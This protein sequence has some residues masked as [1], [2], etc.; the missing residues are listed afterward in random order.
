MTL[1]L[2]VGF[3]LFYLMMMLS[4]VH[5]RSSGQSFTFFHWNL[6]SI[7]VQ[8]YTKVSILTAYTLVHNS[9][10]ICHS[11]TYLNSEASTD[12]QNLKNLV[13]ICYALT[14]FPIIRKEGEGVKYLVSY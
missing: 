11:E 1:P 10:I 9:D 3:S 12:D 6:N 7:S 4:R 13:T 5:V 8:N 2:C 14:I